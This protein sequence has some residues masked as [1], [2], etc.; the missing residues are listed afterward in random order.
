MV[1]S[2]IAME[3]QP[4]R[5]IFGKC[6]NLREKR[7]VMTL[8]TPRWVCAGPYSTF[9]TTTVTVC[10]LQISDYIIPLNMI[11]GGLYMLV[12]HAAII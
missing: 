11:M 1:V 3:L 9:V 10:L 12:L 2:G 8:R 6:S 4:W 5:P 7:G